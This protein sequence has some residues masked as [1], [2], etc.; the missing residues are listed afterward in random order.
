MGK[1]KQTRG[2]VNARALAENKSRE[3]P[4]ATPGEN[5]YAMCTSM[6][7]NNRLLAKCDDGQVRTCKIR[8]NMRRRVW[9]STGDVL[10]V[11]PREFEPDKA[12]VM[13]RYSEAEVS[14]LKRHGEPVAFDNP[15]DDPDLDAAVV[16]DI[17]DL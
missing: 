5:L 17:D 7:G 15:D 9:I 2:V 6:L 10:L 1:G 13:F 4:Y 11:A 14:I 16:F 3:F 8:G 12:D